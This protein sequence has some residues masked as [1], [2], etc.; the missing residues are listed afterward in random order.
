MVSDQQGFPE[1]AP[2]GSTSP[3]EWATAFRQYI[4]TFPPSLVFDPDSLS[5]WFAAALDT[6]KHYGAKQALSTSS[7]RPAE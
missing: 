4:R 1:S 3:Q 6:G 5:K 7:S 2:L